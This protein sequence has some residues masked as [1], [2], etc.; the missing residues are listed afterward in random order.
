MIVGD[1]KLADF[2]CGLFLD[3]NH[4]ITHELCLGV[5]LWYQKRRSGILMNITKQPQNL[6]TNSCWIYR[7]SHFEFRIIAY[8]L[9]SRGVAVVVKITSM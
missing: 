4:L 1:F 6:I 2:S 8:D 5:Y 9:K 7:H 3:N